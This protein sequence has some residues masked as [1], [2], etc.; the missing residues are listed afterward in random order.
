[1]SM[2]RRFPGNFFKNFRDDPILDDTVGLMETG[3]GAA[4]TPSAEDKV[5][6]LATMFAS[7]FGIDGGEEALEVTPADD[8]LT[9]DYIVNS[10]F[11]PPEVR[12]EAEGTTQ[13]V[14]FVQ[15]HGEEVE[16]LQEVNALLRKGWRLQNAFAARGDHGY[17]AL[18]LLERPPAS[19]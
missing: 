5:T 15:E 7:P 3:D 12:G 11:A 18:V 17:A 19:L 10:I 8:Y 13:Q 6:S 2:A 14:F 16:G 9:R 1:M 4:A